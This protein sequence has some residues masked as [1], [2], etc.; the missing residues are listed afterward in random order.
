MENVSVQKFKTVKTPNI[1]FS[2]GMNVKYQISLEQ[3]QV[4][5]KLQ[6]KLLWHH[7][8]QWCRFKGFPPHFLPRK[9][10]EVKTH[11]RLVISLFVTRSP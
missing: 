4:T 8:R 5:T 10:L 11:D 2:T 6:K 1:L 7:G 9:M 3:H